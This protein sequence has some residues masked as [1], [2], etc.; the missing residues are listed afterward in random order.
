MPR[1]VQEL[2]RL[3]EQFYE[4]HL[5]AA[6]EE[7]H[8]HEFVAIDPDSGAYFLGRTLSEAAQAFRNAQP[9]RQ[10]FVMRIGHRAA[11]HLGA[12]LP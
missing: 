10:G 12:T 11:V 2:A 9:G 1:D 4:R 3:S 8:L 6:L 7:A 5:K